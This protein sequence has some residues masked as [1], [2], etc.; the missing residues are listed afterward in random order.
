MTPEFKR[1]LAKTVRIEGGFVNHPADRGGPTNLGITLG[2]YQR[3]GAILGTSYTVEDLRNLD[4]ETAAQ[5][6]YDLYWCD[7]HLP[8]EDMA[9]WWEPIAME[10]F[11]TAVNM[12]PPVAATLLQRSLNLIN[13]NEKAWPDLTVDGWFGRQSLESMKMVDALARGR[14]RLLFAANAYQAKR[15]IDIAEADPTQE[16]FIGGWLLHRVAMSTGTDQ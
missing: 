3:W 7:R 12:S 8:C 5:V 6:Y 2:T 4:P 10:A 14:E 11:D 16:A 15:Y 1:A 13:I 9:A